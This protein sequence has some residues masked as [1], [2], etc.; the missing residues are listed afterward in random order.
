MPFKPLQSGHI[1]RLVRA[2]RILARHDALF[3]L[4][5]MPAPPVSLRIALAL[6]RLRAPWEREPEVG[7]AN[8]LPDRDLPDRP[9]Q[10]LA[11][12][13]QSL[14]PSYIK[15]GQ[16]LATRPDIVSEEMARDLMQL[17]DRLPPFEM[18]V[19]RAEVARDL[20]AEV[21]SFFSEFGPPI[22]A[23]SIAQVHKAQTL[24]G[25]TD[26]SRIVAVKI[27]RP[28]IA[29][30][31]ARDLESFFWLARMI[32]RTQPYFRRLRPVEVVQILADSVALE[33]DLRYE[34]AAASE[35]AENMAGDREFRV[36]QVDWRRTGAQV[37]TIEW[38][39]G[40]PIG[41][42][43]ALRAAGH[44]LG[45]LSAAMIRIFLKQ[46]MRDGFFHADMHQGNL[47]VD[48][49]G[50]IVAVDFGIMGRLDTRNRRYLAEI[51]YGFIRRDY[52]RVAEVHFEAGFVS[53]DKSVDAFAQALRS[54]GEPIFG[55]RAGEISIG[56]LLAQL[57][58]VTETFAMKTQP[59]LLLLQKT[60]VV[61]EGVARSLDPDVDFWAVS[62]PVIKQWMVNNLG[63]EARLAEAAEGA[64]ALARALP[65]LPHWIERAEQAA[66][67][68]H[69]V[70]RDISRGGEAD[71]PRHRLGGWL[72]WAIAAIAVFFLLLQ[73]H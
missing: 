57:F 61:V 13:L 38:V 23:A 47:F 71:R 5:D 35:L 58:R 22:A 4:E 59:Q 2:A 68:N 54:V 29:T 8:D 63:P 32:D 69:A 6:A 11:A 20:G 45:A 67:A 10:R 14:G 66:E 31:F 56:R 37:L 9:G 39:D 1:L 34:A 27:L 40:I 17:Q 3:A 44:D 64:A 36:P 19:A 41:N 43:D 33:M 18:S 48:S 12:A 60:M 73:S 55:L 28:G 50:R 21:E 46:A 49:D 15:L 24:P 51:L 65:N 26:P 52:R 7:T 70:V 16:M 53:R 25:D 72:G 30:A 42:Q 62:E